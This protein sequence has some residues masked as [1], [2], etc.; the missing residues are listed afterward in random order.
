[1]Y[2]LDEDE[3]DALGDTTISDA[4]KIKELKAALPPWL[5]ELADAFSKR[6]ANTL[7]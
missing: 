5:Y 6:A 3:Q 2:S 4:V 1:V 7:P